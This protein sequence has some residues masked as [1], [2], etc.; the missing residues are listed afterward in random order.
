MKSSDFSQLLI[1]KITTPN[2]SAN[3]S[4]IEWEVL[5]RQARASG[6][7]ARL[8]FY[9]KH[10]ANFNVPD[11]VGIHL[12]SAEKFWLSQ[13]RIVKWELYC[14]SLIFDQLKIPLILLKGAAY[15]AKDLDAG[16][17][18]LFNDIDLIVPK[19]RIDE[20]QQ[21]LKIHGWFPEHLEGYDKSYY[22]RWM[23]EIPPLRHIK[24]GTV[25]DIHHN[26]LPQT[27]KI[28]PQA[29]SLLVDAVKIP[30]TAYWTLS[31]GDMILHS[32]SHLFWGGEF[33]NGLRDLSDI[34]LLIREFCIKEN[35]FWEKLITR[36]EFLGL[37]MPLFYAL[38]YTRKILKTPVP[39][40]I[41]S[42]FVSDS[43][44]VAKIQLVDFLFMHALMPDH[45]S[46]DDRWTG[47]ARWT[48]YI[49]S[50]WLRMPPHLLIP[51]LLRKAWMRVSG[52]DPH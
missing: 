51:H 45:P 11:V 7:T 9:R 52:K 50:H 23:H 1:D 3:Y 2:S 28:S 36:A 12:D 21:A 34:D 19:E 33:D 37:E 42:H 18:R 10:S 20:V 13:T 41:A 5:L 48:L 16:F 17:G 22:E 49:R 27:C 8:A 47:L 25:L 6:L 15:V 32:A 26:I 30:N 46:C 44:S 29:E 31:P 24:R 38:R 35:D 14:L 39:E 4:D 43:F 40:E